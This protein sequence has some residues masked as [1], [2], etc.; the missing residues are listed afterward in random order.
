MADGVAQGV[1]TEFKPQ[2]HKKQ[3]IKTCFKV[4][5][6]VYLDKAYLHMT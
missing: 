6:I 5:N 4:Q 3:I 1:S 2:H